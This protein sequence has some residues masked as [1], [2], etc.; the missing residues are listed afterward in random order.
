MTYAEV[1]R[2][3]ESIKQRNLERAKEQ[4][5]FDY[6]LA[7]LIGRSVSRIHSSSNK[8]PS[9]A[10]V[11]PSLFVAA[12]IEEQMQAKKMELSEIRFRQFAES[13]NKRKKGESKSE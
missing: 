7:D 8:M 3:I 13:H 2:E 4:A 10:D 9:I 12:E 11:Y 5:T 1:E 6:I